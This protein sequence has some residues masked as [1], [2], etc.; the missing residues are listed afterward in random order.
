[1]ILVSFA[2][3]TMASFQGKHAIKYR[4]LPITLPRNLLSKISKVR[5]SQNNYPGRQVR[6]V[7]PQV[8]AKAIRSN[9]D[10]VHNPIAS[11]VYDARHMSPKGSQGTV[12]GCYAITATPYPCW[13]FSPNSQVGTR[14]LIFVGQVPDGAKFEV[15]T[16]NGEGFAGA[17]QIS[18]QDN[19]SAYTSS[20]LTNGV[21]SISRATVPE[22]DKSVYLD[23]G[24]GAINIYSIQID[25]FS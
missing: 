5:E 11:L 6:L 17:N 25:F 3:A 7:S 1:M 22:K 18:I 9:K 13:T 21:F 15:I 23:I 4:L 20:K 2:L 8:T 10:P 14:A 12:L 19:A 16:V 24:S